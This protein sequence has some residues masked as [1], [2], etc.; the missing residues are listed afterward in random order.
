VFLRREAE[1]IY[2]REIFAGVACVL[3]NAALFTAFAAYDRGMLLDERIYL[4]DPCPELQDD[5]S[6]EFV[7]MALKDI[8]RYASVWLKGICLLF[9]F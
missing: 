2:I 9:T 7:F 6:A 1:G 5:D 3:V 4:L 8:P